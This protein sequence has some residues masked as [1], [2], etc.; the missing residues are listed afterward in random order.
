ML[1]VDVLVVNHA[2][3]TDRGYRDQQDH[4]AETALGPLRNRLA[5][6]GAGAPE[7]RRAAF[8]AV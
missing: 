1:R 4:G 3:F 6:L 8:L 5:G 7:R 2:V